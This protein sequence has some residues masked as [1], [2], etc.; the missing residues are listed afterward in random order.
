MKQRLIYCL[1]LAT[2]MLSACA[3]LLL[4]PLALASEPILHQNTSAAP[5]A[6][7]LDD[8]NVIWESPGKYSLDSMPL[9]NGDVG[10]N[11]WIDANHPVIRVTGQSGSLRTIGESVTNVLGAPWPNCVFRDNVLY[12]H[13]GGVAP[14]H[15]AKVVSTKRLSDTILKVE[16]DQPLEPIARASISADSLTAGK[17]GPVVDFDRPRTF[18][19]LE[20]T[21]DNPG[22]R[23]GQTKPF[24]LQV[25]QADG[26]WKTVASGQ[27]FGSIYSKRF[28][29]ATAQHV[30]LN[31][32]ALVR[33]FDLLAAGK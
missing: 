32:S 9:G 12:V 5:I 10:A 17:S 27:V 28:A 16:Y 8:C 33:Q 25:Q 19:Q 30:R 18:D 29:P 4:A 26:S 11:V 6:R 24:E 2:S 14:N 7:T 23:R 1:A 13:G 3:A 15:P 21:I 22:Y 31:V 20:F